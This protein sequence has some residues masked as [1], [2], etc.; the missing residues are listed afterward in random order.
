MG[1]CLWLRYFQQS[2][3]RRALLSFSLLLGPISDSKSQISNLKSQ[4]LEKVDFWGGDDF[5][6]L[7][8]IYY[9][10][11]GRCYRSFSGFV[12]FRRWLFIRP[13]LEQENAHRGR[14]NRWSDFTGIVCFYY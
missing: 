10:D 6:P 5:Y 11:Q 9:P 7:P 8:N 1:P 12:Y 2:N 13:R 3:I 4:K 14:H